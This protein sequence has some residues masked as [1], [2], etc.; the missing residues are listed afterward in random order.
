MAKL[1]M[2]NIIANGRVI[3]GFFGASLDELTPEGLRESKLPSTYRT[4]V[5]I[6]N[7]SHE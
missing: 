6:Q 7:V 4:G 5:L 3:R 1:I 2:D